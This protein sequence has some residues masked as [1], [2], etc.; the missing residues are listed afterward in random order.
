MEI[1]KDVLHEPTGAIIPM[2]VNGKHYKENFEGR[3][4]FSADMICTR[5]NLPHSDVAKILL[6]YKVPG[7]IRHNDFHK[8]RSGK[9]P[10]D[11]ALFFEEYIYGI[12]DKTGMEHSKLKAK[13]IHKIDFGV[14]NNEL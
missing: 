2:F 5:W 1:K 10:L 8:I 14:A 9:K 13:E 7:H 11:V 6:R 3:K 12:E 4:A